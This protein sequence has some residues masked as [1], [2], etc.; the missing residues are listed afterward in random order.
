MRSI[1]KEPCTK[2]KHAHILLYIFISISALFYIQKLND[3]ALSTNDSPSPER[4]FVLLSTIS[5]L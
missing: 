3:F 2:F 4:P 5:E 1:N